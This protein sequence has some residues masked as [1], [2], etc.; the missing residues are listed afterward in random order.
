MIPESH[1]GSWAGPNRLWLEPGTPVHRSEGTLTVTGTELTYTWSYQGAP[2]HGRLQWF[3]PLG[4]MRAEWQ[5]TWHNT[6]GS[7]YHGRAGEGTA[8]F[9][10]TYPAGDGPEWGWRISLDWRDPEHFLVRMYNLVPPSYAPPDGVT[11]LAV[12]LRGARAS[13]PAQ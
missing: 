4:S 10:G 12:D 1:R 6:G 2:H 9:Y 3:G 11:A 13:E 7:T 5:D 8:D